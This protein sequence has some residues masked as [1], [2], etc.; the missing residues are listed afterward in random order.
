MKVK[1]S[2]I[3]IISE[4]RENGRIRLTTLS[5]KTKMPIS[6]IHERLKKHVKS[7]LLKSTALLQFDKIGYNTRAHILLAVDQTDKEKLFKYLK[8]HPNV[9]TLYK[10]NNGWNL[11]MECIFEDMYS[12]EEFVENIENNN[13]IKRKEIH[14]VLEELKKERFLTSNI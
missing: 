9:N 11:M 5:K 6:T 1:K 14:Y 3:K 13:T 4:L 2:D 10:I 8:N 12:L 7:G